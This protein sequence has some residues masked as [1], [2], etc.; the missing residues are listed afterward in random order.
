MHRVVVCLVLACLSVQTHFESIAAA[1]ENTLQPDQV[2]QLVGK[3]QSISSTVLLAERFDDIV[4]TIAEGTVD[5]ANAVQSMVLKNASLNITIMVVDGETGLFS[6]YKRAVVPGVDLPGIERIMGRAV[7][8]DQ[9]TLSLQFSESADTA[10]W[11]AKVFVS[12]GRMEAQRVEGLEVIGPDGE[13]LDNQAVSYFVLQKDAG[14]FDL[15][16]AAKEASAA[17]QNQKGASTVDAMGSSDACML[18]HHMMNSLF[19]MS[20]MFVVVS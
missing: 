13:V 5:P 1:T 4:P 12:N 3:Y 14:P 17:L 16:T 15:T 11:E 19:I 2:Q 18:R 8:L 9:D 10:L 20:I 7:P 6:G